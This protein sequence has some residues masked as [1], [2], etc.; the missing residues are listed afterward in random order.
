[1]ASSGYFKDDGKHADSNAGQTEKVSM[2]PSS[3]FTFPLTRCIRQTEKIK[4]D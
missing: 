3:L 2:F 1:M 4:K